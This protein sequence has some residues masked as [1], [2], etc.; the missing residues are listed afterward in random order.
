MT[1]TGGLE[2]R[3]EVV[4][5]GEQVNEAVNRRLQQWSRT[6]KIKGFRP[7]KVPFAVIRSQ[8]GDQAHVEA[9]QDLMQSSYAEAV[10]QQKL[11][12]A[13]GPRIEPINVAPGGE[14][15]YA[16]V[17]EVMPEIK[18]APLAEL[19]VERP[20]ATVTD[21]DV[22]DMVERMRKQRPVYSPVERLAAA[23]DRVT[24]DY[25]GRIDG[26]IFAGGK[27]DGLQV[28]VG[29]GN[30]LGELDAALVGM[31]VGEAKSVAARFP[32]D[33]GARNVA[34]KTATFSLRVAAV[35]VASTPELNDEFA[36]TVGLPEGNLEALRAEVRKGMERELA[37]HVRRR[38]REALLEALYLANP[39]Q[40]PKVLVDEQVQEM[41]LQMLRRMG[42]EPKADTPL[43]P[44][45][46]YQEPARKRVAL[47]L[48]VGD[49][50]RGQ[51][52]AV[53]RQ[54]VE[55]RLTAAVS[56]SED[57]LNL[58][59]QYLQSREAMQQIES[60]ALEDQTI[61]WLLGQVQVREK[62]VSFTELTGYTKP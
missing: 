28:I 32:D 3:M 31:G 56:G 50:V 2:R 15:K 61:D 59:R 41:Q 47:G 14:L 38:T 6:A 24:L 51:N 17:F 43:P 35:E 30:I 62:P 20:A 29:A 13:A 11:R 39:L 58:R 36:K 53:D 25:E 55:E 23:G 8:Y 10:D 21:E 19:I 22:A 42:A 27:G 52:F 33:Y 40:L 7:G 44:R 18:L 5:P 48:L 26:E 60:A 45:E 4:V 16:A 54:R 34:G 9:I 49:I 1:E 37:D 57:P 12:P 46:P